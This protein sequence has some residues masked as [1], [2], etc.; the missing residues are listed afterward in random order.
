MTARIED[1][2]N[3][4]R[5]ATKACCTARLELVDALVSGLDVRARQGDVDDTEEVRAEVERHLLALLRTREE[6]ATKC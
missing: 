2:A 6:K 1:A 5:A 3:R 4:L